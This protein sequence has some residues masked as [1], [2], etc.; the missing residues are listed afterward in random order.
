M[1]IPSRPIAFRCCRGR[2]ADWRLASRAR[3][4][5]FG[6]IVFAAPVAYASVSGKR[7]RGSGNELADLFRPVTGRYC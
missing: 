7:D 5:W 1:P 2:A 4:R 3:C 6:R